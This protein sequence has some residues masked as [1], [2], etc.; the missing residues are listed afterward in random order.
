MKKSE[1]ERGYLSAKLF[2]VKLCLVPLIILL[3]FS[4]ASLAPVGSPPGAEVAAEAAGL[5]EKRVPVFC[6]GSDHLSLHPTAG[7]C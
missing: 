3:V 6:C 7:P 2:I 5:R 4:S 1:K